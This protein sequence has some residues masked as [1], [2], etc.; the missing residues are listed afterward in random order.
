M[1]VVERVSKKLDVLVVADLL[2]QS[3]K[4][5]KVRKY[6]IPIMHEAIFWKLLGIEVN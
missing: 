6:G 4:A 1:I 3:G 2:S 5:R